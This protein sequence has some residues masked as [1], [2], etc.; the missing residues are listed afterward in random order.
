[1]ETMTKFDTMA[2]KT[3]DTFE[4]EF[5]SAISSVIQGTSSMKDALGNMFANMS[6]MFADMV[7]QMIAKWATL[8]LVKGLGSM[9]GGG[10]LPVAGA[11][12][13]AV[14]SGFQPFSA[15]AIKPFANG[16]VVKGPTLGLVGEGRYN[17][18][19]VPLPDGKKIPVE[20][21]KNA[22]GNVSSSVVVNISNDGGSESSTK[23]SQGNQLAKGIEGAVKD[24]IMREM[25][26]GGMIA[27]RK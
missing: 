3:A 26:P 7:A 16:G 19:V 9:F 27:S 24:V 2:I 4:Q 12:N 17:E 21:G 11:A 22:G 25:R 18:A 5:G 23:G 15:N 13:G 8:Q 10:A 14:W 20:M 6:K 1:M